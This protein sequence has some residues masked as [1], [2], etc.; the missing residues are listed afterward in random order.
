MFGTEASFND[1]QQENRWTG[2]GLNLKQFYTLF[3]G[4]W[5]LLGVVVEGGGCQ[6][7]C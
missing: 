6:S 1:G 5:W 7:G 3:R 4:C 2:L